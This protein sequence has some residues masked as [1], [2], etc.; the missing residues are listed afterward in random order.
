MSMNED[1]QR[2]VVFQEGENLRAVAAWR[3]DPETKGLVIRG[4][5]LEMLGT[6]AMGIPR[7]NSCG[8]VPD[9]RNSDAS[10]WLAALLVGRAERWVKENV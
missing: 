1:F 6:D 8:Y 10:Q 2:A 9:Q 5:E 4:I 3:R 7:W